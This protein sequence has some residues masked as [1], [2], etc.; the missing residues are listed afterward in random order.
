[1]YYYTRTTYHHKF[2][3]RPPL[4]LLLPFSLSGRPPLTRSLAHSHWIDDCDIIKY[5]NQTTRQAGRQVWVSECPETNM[6]FDG[7]VEH[8]LVHYRWVFVLFLLPISFVYDIYF[9]TRN[10]IVFFLSSAPRRH[11]EKVQK[12]Q[13]QVKEWKERHNDKPMC[14]A[15]PG[16]YLNASG[17]FHE[18]FLR[19]YWN[20]Y[21]VWGSSTRQYNVPSLWAEFLGSC[22]K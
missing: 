6:D 22:M 8:I 9:Y 12:I 10:R 17:Q 11:L 15:R 19:T 5:P 4:S 7:F 20:R 13:A 16:K 18:D 1:M 14:T 2:V 21:L 3:P